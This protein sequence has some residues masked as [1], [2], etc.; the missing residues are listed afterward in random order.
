MAASELARLDVVRNLNSDQRRWIVV[1][2]DDPTGT[3][4]TA[5]APV[6]LGEWTDTDLLE[7]GR[8]PSGLCFIETNSRSLDAQ[9]AARAVKSATLAALRVA[10]QSG[11]HLTVV[12]RSDSTLRGHFEPELNAALD[13]F[14][15]A[16]ISLDG[17]IFAPAFF[18]AG[19]YTQGD[20]QWVADESGT[21]PAAETE[22]AND[23]TFGFSE[24]S[25][26]D[27]VR[28]RW[29][30]RQGQV[31]T[32]PPHALRSL[33]ESRD[34][35]IV[36]ATTYHEL[37]E[38]VIE[39]YEREK[40]GARYLFRTGPSA[41]RAMSGQAQPATGDA[42]LSRGIAGHGLV[43]AGSHTALT[44]RQLEELVL[45]HAPQ[46]VELNLSLVLDDDPVSSTA[47]SRRS[48]DAAVTALRQGLTLLQTSRDDVPHSANAL[49][50]TRWIADALAV[51]V[52]NVCEQEAPGYVI[53]KGGITSSDLAAKSLR[54]RRATV[55][56]QAFPGQVPVWR[57][58]DGPAAGTP[59]V[60][61]PG[62][63][64]SPTA[65]ASVVSI[66]EG[67]EAS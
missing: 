44:N 59:Y 66:L 61:F 4:T 3:Q 2:D 47:E 64:G 20:V 56:G 34:V 16:G 51:A 31:L 52:R 50:T 9:D 25:L 8:H 33:R 65:L 39:A 24:R 18:E 27:W 57:L 58:E 41:V 38:Q 48:V 30:T 6:L 45:Q 67:K 55:L 22:F 23:A 19:R 21:R 7:A 60:V 43:V 37:I 13:A 17:I 46:V 40:S 35:A 63:V 32:V 14:V 15:Q 11:L 12:S 53:A 49:E 62:N 1:L 54:C 26:R 10:D 5:G 42:C 29:A 28:H 36:E